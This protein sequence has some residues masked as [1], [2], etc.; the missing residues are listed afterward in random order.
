[1]THAAR[2][3]VQEALER[4]LKRE[5]PPCALLISI[6]SETFTLKSTHDTHAD[7]ASALAKA[8]PA[9]VLLRIGPASQDDAHAESAASYALA[10]YNPDDAPVRDKML[11]S[12]AAD[13]LRRVLAAMITIRREAHWSSLDEVDVAALLVSPADTDTPEAMTSLEKLKLA[14]DAATAV[15][16][17]GARVASATLSLPPTDGACQALRE[18]NDG[19]RATLLLQI[20]DESL[21]LLPAAPAADAAALRSALP[22]FE[23]AY[24]AFRFGLDVAGRHGT[25]APMCFVYSCPEACHVRTKMIHAANKAAVVSWLGSVGLEVHK[26]FEIRDLDDLSDEMLRAELVVEPRASSMGQLDSSAAMNK[27]KPAPR[28]GRKLM[29]KPAADARG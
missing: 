7:A 3:A 2:F 10:T 29:R 18:L 4:T 17:A 16:A 27:A 9:Y 6:V 28:G 8:E 24:A 19:A 14:D 15:E 22:R 21:A 12:A 25:T 1:M 13:T 26:T 20:V 23:P 5:E 11:A